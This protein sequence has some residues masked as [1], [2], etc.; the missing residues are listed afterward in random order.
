MSGAGVDSVTRLP[1]FAPTVAS[2][3]QAGGELLDRRAVNRATLARQMLLKPARVSVPEALEHLVG[4]QA[5]A[6]HAPYVGLWSRLES[7]R[8]EELAE[9]LSSRHAVRA[10]LM[11]AT[12]HLVTPRDFLRIR[13]VVQPVLE[14]GFAGTPFDVEGIDMPQLLEVGRSLLAEHPL[15]RPELGAAL[16][17]RWP[18]TIRPRWPMRSPTWCRSCRCPRARCGAQV[19][20][21]AGLRPTPGWTGSRTA[22]PARPR[23]TSSRSTG[24]E[25]IREEGTRLLGFADPSV[26]TGERHVTF[27]SP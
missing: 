6:P 9:L 1:A 5:Q 7:F 23:F 15:S 11:R 17:S 27:T 21:R 3:G 16:A 12:I 13:P 22:G 20:R 26:D 25:A 19:A 2:M 4:M 24:H 18:D 10:P 8:A 14:R